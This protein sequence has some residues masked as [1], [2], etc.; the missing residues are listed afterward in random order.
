MRT[1]PLSPAALR[2]VKS[3]RAAGIAVTFL[4][5]DKTN[6][7]ARWSLS[8]GATI[9]LFANGATNRRDPAP[10][11]D[12]AWAHAPLTAL[13]AREMASAYPEEDWDRWKEEMKER[14]WE[15]DTGSLPADQR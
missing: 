6:A 13:V 3:T 7:V 1:H 11:V 5:A 2:L 12:D 14:E 4:P 15:E 9:T 10:V 8:D